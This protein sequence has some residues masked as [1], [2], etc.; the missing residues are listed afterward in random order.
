MPEPTGLQAICDD[1]KAIKDR[2]AAIANVEERQK[3]SDAAD[4]AI[5]ARIAAIEESMRRQ[6]ISLPGSEGYAKNYSV[7]RAMRAWI[8]NKWDDAGLEREMHQ[9]AWKRLPESHNARIMTTLTPS[10]GGFLVPEEIFAGVIPKFDAMSVC[11]KAGAT[12]ISPKGSPFKINKVTAGATAAYA[13]EGSAPSAS[14]LTLGQVSMAPRK[15]AARTVMTAEQVQFGTPAT[16]ALVVQDLVLRTELLQDQWALNGTGQQGQPIG[17][18]NTTGIN[19]AAGVSTTPADNL[20]WADVA[21]ALQYLDEDNVPLDNAAIVLHPTQKW[22][23]FRNFYSTISSGTIAASGA[24][25]IAGIP[26]MTAQ[27]FKEL[28]GLTLFSTT[29]QT[30]GTGI[31]GV[32]SDLWMAEWGGMVVGASN[33]ASDGTHHAWVDDKLHVKVTRWIDSAVIRPVAF[34]TITSI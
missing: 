16:D 8:N 15:I 12:V 20:M 33:V 7:G 19:T 26:I 34:H 24:A 13:A 31:V 29:Q 14:D 25:F 28:T 6:S 22:E 5:A 30:D 18:E 1:I 32:F 23:L 27:R 4:A 3:A 17:I 10:A 2:V 11:K 21:T 9:E